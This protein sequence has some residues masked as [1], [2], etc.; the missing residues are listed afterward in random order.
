[1]SDIKITP[2]NLP[3]YSKRLQRA[4][5]SKLNTKLSLADSTTLLAQAL[6][7]PNSHQLLQWLEGPD[8]SATPPAMEGSPSAFL[9][10]VWSN[11]PPSTAF[12]SIDLVHHASTLALMVTAQ[13]KK[14]RPDREGFGL[15]WE[16]HSHPSDYLSKELSR[17]VHTAAD[18]Q[19]LSEIAIQFFS[20]KV[21][22]RKVFAI[23]LAEGL[24]LEDG[25]F[26]RLYQ[27]QEKTR[28]IYSLGSC[29]EIFMV[30]PGIIL[31]Y[32][33]TIRGFAEGCLSMRNHPRHFTFESA[34]RQALKEGGNVLHGYCHPVTGRMVFDWMVSP[35]ALLIYLTGE[36]TFPYKEKTDIAVF[37][38]MMALTQKN[39]IALNPYGVNEPEHIF[40]EKG[41]G[42]I[43]Q[44]RVKAPV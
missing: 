17:L 7:A 30:H 1:M 36:L 21:S 20:Q 12:D 28:E 43:L 10:W 5:E 14:Y 16:G 6:G 22:S 15:Y 13:S 41:Y 11:I 3:K 18:A 9:S 37:Q 29:V 32:E 39:D 27:A 35:D 26:F 40:W 42:S 33:Q 34:Y 23:Q 31:A 8:T 38:G 44:K 25:R 19:F 24:G 4:I 2:A